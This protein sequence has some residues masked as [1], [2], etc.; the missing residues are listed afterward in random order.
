MPGSGLRPLARQRRSIFWT[1]RC[2]IDPCCLLRHANE[3]SVNSWRVLCLLGMVVLKDDHRSKATKHPKKEMRHAIDNSILRIL[4]YDSH[5]GRRPVHA[6]GKCA[7]TISLLITVNSAR[8][9]NRARK[10]FR[11]QARRGRRRRK[12]SGH[13]LGTST[14]RNWPKR[15]SPKRNV[16]LVRPTTPWKRW[17]LTKA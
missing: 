2:R 4:R 12:N 15:L 1:S 17:S 14:N 7:A 5:R 3:T 11:Q 6:R 13:P 16:S 9:E 8:P 10:Y